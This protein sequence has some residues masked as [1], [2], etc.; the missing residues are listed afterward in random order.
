M[1]PANDDDGR[2]DYLM[3]VSIDVSEREKA[4]AEIHKLNM[5]LVR[6]VLERSAELAR[7]NKEPGASTYSVSHDLRSPLRHIDGGADSEFRRIPVAML[8]SSREGRDRVVSYDLGSNAYIV[9]PVNFSDFVMSV[10]SPEDFRAVLNE[11]PP[12]S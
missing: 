3:V 9:K 2:L 5:S 4:E 10:K 11:P 7:A 8:T 6:R 12:Q 1:V